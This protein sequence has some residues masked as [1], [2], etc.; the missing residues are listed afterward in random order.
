M[1]SQNPDIP[2]NASSGKTKR[3][4]LSGIP[5]LRT[6]SARFM[7]LST[8]PS[9]GANCLPINGNNMETAIANIPEGKQSSLL[10]CAEVPRRYET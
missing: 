1:Q 3:S 10:A 4:K 5:W 6:A 8:S 9:C 2:E 7:L